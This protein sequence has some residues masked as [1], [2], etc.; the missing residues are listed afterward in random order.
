MQNDA[1]SGKIKNKP[2]YIKISNEVHRSLLWELRDVYGDVETAVADEV[3][4]ALGNTVYVVD[5]GREE[6]K[7]TCRAIDKVVIEDQT[8]REEY[9][10]RKNHDALSKGYISD[11]LSGRFRSR[12]ADNRQG[13]RRQEVRS[14][15][16]TDNGKSANNQSGVSKA[17]ATN[18]GLK[19]KSS[20][21]LD[22][23]YL[24][25]VNLGDMET[26]QRM[27]DEAAKL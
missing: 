13:N 9:I 12:Y 25:A 11:G 22:I 16:Q 4:V 23:K 20:H 18:R 7:I 5:S 14:N 6:G 1:K 24:D 17:N 27:V 21:E 3:A 19:S 2:R 26:A 8:L 10:R 15:L